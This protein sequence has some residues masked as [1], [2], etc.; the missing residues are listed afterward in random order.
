M[1]DESR[2]VGG[3]NQNGFAQQ[4]QQVSLRRTV[5][6]LCSQ[7]PHTAAALQLARDTRLPF[8]AVQEIVRSTD[9]ALQLLS[10]DGNPRPLVM[11]AAE[12]MAKARI[13][14]RDNGIDDA[15]V[16]AYLRELP[17]R[18]YEML[19]LFKLGRTPSQI[20]TSLITSKD[21]VRAILARIYAG[22]RLR[23]C[24]GP[25]GD[26]GEPAPC[27]IDAGETTLAGRLAESLV[28]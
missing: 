20:A 14:D 3:E 25:D 9:E 12:R 17:D 28:A 18:D 24:P 5:H 11:V 7:D 23:L 27:P 16:H 1:K 8:A 22:L 4:R 6:R 19:R 21:E 13:G 2:L 15:I 26:G 10:P